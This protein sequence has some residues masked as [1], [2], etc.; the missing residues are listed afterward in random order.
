MGWVVVVCGCCLCIVGM[1]DCL[2][3]YNSLIFLL[4]LEDIFYYYRLI[5]ISWYLY[6][7]DNKNINNLKTFLLS[8]LFSM[9]IFLL[10]I[11]IQINMIY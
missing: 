1:T 11:E 9:L 2:E 5:R 7:E 10:I 6:N 8:F 4:L 3:A